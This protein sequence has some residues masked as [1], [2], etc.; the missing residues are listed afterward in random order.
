MS[1]TLQGVVI[2]KHLPA[3]WLTILTTAVLVAAC[4][5]SPTEVE[6]EINPALLEAAAES[7]LA[8]GLGS[9]LPQGAAAFTGPG[10]MLMDATAEEFIQQL[11]LTNGTVLRTSGVSIRAVPD[12]TVSNSPFDR[13]S[14]GAANTGSLASVSAG[15]YNIAP[16]PTFDFIQQLRFATAGVRKAGERTVVYA[17]SGVVT[18][19]SLNYFNDV[20]PCTLIGVTLIIERCDYRIGLVRG[21]IEFRLSLDGGATQLVQARTAFTLPIK[22]Q[23]IVARMR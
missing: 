4:S 13:L 8:P 9:N 10:G 6:P 19:E 21:T 18:I 20:Y 12:E 17:P 3:R 22:K 1:S 23:T 16:L 7:N 11:T 14:F 5:D 2:M 15:T